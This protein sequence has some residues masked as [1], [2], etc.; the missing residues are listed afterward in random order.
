M[1]GVLRV[2][3]E[4]DDR[5]PSLSVEQPRAQFSDVRLGDVE[6]VRGQGERAVDPFD[7]GEEVA[8]EAGRSG[9]DGRRAGDRMVLQVEPDPAV[10]RPAGDVTVVEQ[11]HRFGG[12]FRKERDL[13]GDGRRGDGQGGDPGTA[14]AQVLLQPEAK[15]VEP[16]TGLRLRPRARRTG[17]DAAGAVRGGRFVRRAGE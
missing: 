13:L 16:A 9:T 8:D 10:V 6:D 12:W 1:V 7:G 5:H 4:D 17:G 2:R 15:G 14:I 3:G 11:M